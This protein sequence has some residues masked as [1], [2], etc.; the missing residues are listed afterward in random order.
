MIPESTFR[1]MLSPS[2]NIV[3]CISA[4]IISA[5]RSGSECSLNTLSTSRNTSFIPPPKAPIATGTIVILYPGLNSNTIYYTSILCHQ[6][7]SQVEHG[8]V[9]ESSEL[10]DKELESLFNEQLTNVNHSTMTEI[11]S[12]ASLHI[13]RYSFFF[14]LSHATCIHGLSDLSMQ[15]AIL[16][17]ISL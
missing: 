16:S 14:S 1:I 5:N 7:E 3:F 12:C 10:I 6:N 8:V 13:D 11:A 15:Q 4:T 17:F 9:M 2:I